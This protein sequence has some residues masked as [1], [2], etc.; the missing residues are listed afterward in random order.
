[1]SDYTKGPWVAER[2]ECHFGSLSTVTGGQKSSSGKLESELIIQVGGFTGLLEQEA[3]TRLVATAP[4]LLEFVRREMEE[5]M[6]IC[7]FAEWTTVKC[8]HCETKNLVA[9]AE[10]R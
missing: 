8:T 1:M 7:R 9:K 3:N 5:T 4:E 2:D 10:G 6:C